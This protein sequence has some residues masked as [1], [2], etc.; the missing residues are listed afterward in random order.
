MVFFVTFEAAAVLAFI[1]ARTG[2]ATSSSDSEE[3]SIF[4]SLAQTPTFLGPDLSYRSRL[5]ASFSAFFSLINSL[6][7]G[8]EIIST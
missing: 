5:A 3:D 1:L 7:F 8:S 6:T 2:A 4:A